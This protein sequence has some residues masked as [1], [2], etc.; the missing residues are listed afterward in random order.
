MFGPG[1]Q[2]RLFQQETIK[3]KNVSETLARFGHYFKPYWPVLLFAAV[4]VI[5]STWAQVTTPDLIGQ[6][7]DCYLVPAGASAFGSFPGASPASSSSTASSCWFSKPAADLSLTQR[8]LKSMLTAGNFPAPS[9]AASG[10]TRDDRL[11]GLGR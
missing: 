7:V 5:I 9:T 4:L 1:G 8:T 10:M 11:A 2:A 6:T 3:P